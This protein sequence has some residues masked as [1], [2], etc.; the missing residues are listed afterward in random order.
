MAMVQYAQGSGGTQMVG[1]NVVHHED[2]SVCKLPLNLSCF[3][4]FGFYFVRIKHT[5]NI[6]TKTH[7][8]SEDLI[9][10]NC[11][12]RILLFPCPFELFIL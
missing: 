11:F 6:S 7:I 2:L 12:A 5:Q 4:V 3:N 9:E 10:Q 8:C 1:N